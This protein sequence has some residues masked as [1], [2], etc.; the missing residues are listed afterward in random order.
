V[1]LR[2]RQA[3]AATVPKQSALDELLATE[4]EIAA[5]MAAAERAAE[6]LVSAARAEADAIAHK[7]DE[8]LAA[9]LARLVAK[10]Q[11]LPDRAIASLA[12]FIVLEAT[13][14]GPGKP[15]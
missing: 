1:F 2:T 11:T 10:F 4:R 6:S 14:L 13:G 15:Q 3:V 8:A 7:A 9:E 12:D 5:Q